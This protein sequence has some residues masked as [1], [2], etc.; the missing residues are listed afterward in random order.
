MHHHD[1]S[2]TDISKRSRYK[3]T[4][5]LEQTTAVWGETQVPPFQNLGNL[6]TKHQARTEGAKSGNVR[7]NQELSQPV[8]TRSLWR[9]GPDT[10]QL[11]SAVATLYEP[12]SKDKACAVHTHPWS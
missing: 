2:I 4:V 1:R 7:G 8:K 3:D 6:Q 9:E 5:T 11:A 10:S 12:N